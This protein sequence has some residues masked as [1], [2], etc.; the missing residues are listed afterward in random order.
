MDGGVFKFP[1]D[2][3]PSHSSSGSKRNS[4]QNE[5]RPA[6]WEVSTS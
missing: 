1:A 3:S 5:E 2:D 4:I 6:A